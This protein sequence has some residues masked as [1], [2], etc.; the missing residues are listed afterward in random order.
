MTTIQNGGY[1]YLKFGNLTTNDSDVFKTRYINTPANSYAKMSG[2]PMCLPPMNHFQNNKNS[3][4]SPQC[5]N[6]HVSQTREST[7]CSCK[8]LSVCPHRNSNVY[9]IDNN[10]CFQENSKI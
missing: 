2:L 1:T 5:G 8:N 7:T 9:F 10:V 6:P 4:I 3:A